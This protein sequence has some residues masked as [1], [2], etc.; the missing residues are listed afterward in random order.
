[1]LFN[2]MD[3]CFFHATLQSSSSLLFQSFACG[4][5]TLMG[6]SAAIPEFGNACAFINSK[7]GTTDREYLKHIIKDLKQLLADPSE[8]D[9]LSKDGRKLAESFSHD[10]ISAQFINLI[11]AL[12]QQIE[13]QAMSTYSSF[14]NLFC[15]SYNG[16]HGT[17]RSQALQLPHYSAETIEVGLAKEFLKSH[18]RLQA[19]TLLTEICDGDKER[20]YHILDTLS[21]SVL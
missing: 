17:I 14:P 19:E 1:M 4:V 2:A 18:S 3:I 12:T 10:A 5:P 9:R 15:Y 8:M 21:G 6:T 13:T 7:R 11:H 16:A 20:A